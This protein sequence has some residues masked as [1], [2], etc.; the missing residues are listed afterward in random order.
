MDTLK[1][2][3]KSKVVVSKEKVRKSN[4]IFEYYDLWGAKVNL[5]TTFLMRLHSRYGHKNVANLLSW[6]ADY[7]V[8]D[9]SKPP[10][11]LAWWYMKNKATNI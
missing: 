2:I 5:P 3:L 4:P 6:L 8:K 11:G 9:R 1:D 10:M 7:P